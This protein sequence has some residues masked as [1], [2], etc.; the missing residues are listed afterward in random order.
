MD[1]I[2]RAQWP[3]RPAWIA[4]AGHLDGPRPTTALATSP[5][6]AQRFAASLRRFTEEGPF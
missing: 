6:E 3:R 4:P 5:G 2:E 1:G